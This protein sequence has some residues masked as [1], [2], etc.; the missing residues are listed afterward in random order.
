MAFRRKLGSPNRVASEVWV[1]PEAG[2]SLD[3]ILEECVRV[4]A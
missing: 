3:E 4:V 2:L 1:K